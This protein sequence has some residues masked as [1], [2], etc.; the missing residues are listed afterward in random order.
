MPRQIK[1]YGEDLAALE[2]AFKDRYVKT[3][4]LHRFV[5]VTRLGEEEERELEGQGCK[6]TRGMNFSLD[7]GDDR[8]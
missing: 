2:E 5:V 3:N 6:V 4:I 1:I 7:V 8:K